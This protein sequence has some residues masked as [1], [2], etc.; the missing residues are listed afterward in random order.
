MNSLRHSAF[1][2]LLFSAFADLRAA[3]LRLTCDRVPVTGCDYIFYGHTNPISSVEQAA[4]F[5]NAGT[6]NTVVIEGLQGTWYFRCTAAKNGFESD[7]GNQVI[8]EVPPAPTGLRL[9][10]EEI[11]RLMTTNSAKF[12][13]MRIE[14]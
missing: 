3:D 13:R 7:P 8:V 11:P 12:F 10:V 2:I 14:N 4:T 1:V 5:Y 6:N 9:V